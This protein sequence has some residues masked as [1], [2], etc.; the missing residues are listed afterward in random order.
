MQELVQGSGVGEGK[1]NFSQLCSNTSKVKEAAVKSESMEG[2]KGM[3]GKA[4]KY[5]YLS[6]LCYGN[7]PKVG[8]NWVIG[9]RIE[10]VFSKLNEEGMENSRGQ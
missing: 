1:I 9:K 8:I 6:N 7:M 3:S 10:Y 5:I 4:N 2:V